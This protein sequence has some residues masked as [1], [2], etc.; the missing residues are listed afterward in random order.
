[1]LLFLDFDHVL[2]PLN[3][4]HMADLLCRR[5]L[6]EDVLR[7]VPWVEV[8]I[9]STW[10]ETRALAQLQALFSPDIA[11]RIVGVTPKWHAVDV[12][13]AL[14]GYRRHAEIQGWLN[15]N[16][17]NLEGWLTL[18]DQPWLFRPFLKNLVRIPSSTG[19]TGALCKHL[20]CRP[21]EG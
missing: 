14:V 4:S 21:S 3:T 18:D 12:S 2:H 6:L 20:H 8:V 7:R 13:S 5:P 17:R 16:Q 1:M 19:L 10:A 11:P 15:A 9:S